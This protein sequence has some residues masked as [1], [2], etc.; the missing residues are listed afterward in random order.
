MEKTDLGIER[1]FPLDVGKELVEKGD[2]TALERPLKDL[3]LVLRGMFFVEKNQQGHGGQLG[4]ANDPAV[5]HE[6]PERVQSLRFE[7][8]SGGRQLHRFAAQL[9]H[10]RFFSLGQEGIGPPFLRRIDDGTTHEPESSEEK[11]RHSS[12]DEEA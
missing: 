12:E 6:P 1:L 2:I 7:L 5:L 8:R 4:H 3:F 11:D 9:F 10:G